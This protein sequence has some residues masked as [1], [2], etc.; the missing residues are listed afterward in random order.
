MVTLR[1]ATLKIPDLV[2]FAIHPKFLIGTFGSLVQYFFHCEFSEK[3][4]QFFLS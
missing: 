3:I 1:A 4:F 2:F